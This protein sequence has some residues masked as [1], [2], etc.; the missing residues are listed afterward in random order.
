MAESIIHKQKAL[1]F[2]LEATEGT[3][4]NATAAS[5]IMTEDLAITPVVAEKDAVEVWGSDIGAVRKEV[6]GDKHSEASFKVPLTW[7]AVAPTSATVGLLA[8]A[9][10]F[11]ACGAKP[12][13]FS[14]AV[15]GPPAVPARLTY[16]ELDDTSTAKSGSAHIRRKRAS[17][18]HLARKMAGSRGSVSLDWEIGKIPRFGFNFIGSALAVENATALT[19]AATTALSSLAETQMPASISLVKLNAIEVCMTKLS[20][21]NLFRLNP[22]WTAFSCGSRAQPSPVTDND[23][24]ITF[25][26]PNIT[27]EFNP[28]DY[29]GKEYPLEFKAVQVDGARALILSYPTLQVTDY[30]EVEIGDE[31]GIEMT[32]R[33]TSKLSIITE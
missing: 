25:K 5:F 11:E 3:L 12:A 33:Q 27:T 14:A 18:A 26:H 13:T 15:V 6:I 29:I 4:V 7:P 19:A 21:K 31:L 23:I 10:L 2:L 8:L 9:P 16:T 28:D 22:T 32:L 17:A 1:F 30:K 20:I 24:T